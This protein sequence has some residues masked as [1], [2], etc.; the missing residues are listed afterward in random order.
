LK[1]EYHLFYFIYE[2]QFKTASLVVSTSPFSIIVVRASINRTCCREELLPSMCRVRCGAHPRSFTNMLTSLL[3]PGAV[4]SRI[5]GSKPQRACHPPP[6]ISSASPPH[7]FASSRSL[8][9]SPPTARSSPHFTPPM[10]TATRDALPQPCLSLPPSL[11]PPQP[12]SIYHLLLL[13]CLQ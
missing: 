5:C 4:R 11:L 1:Y 7:D 8:S 12:Q 9:G 3:F 10:V 2:N 13:L 6:S